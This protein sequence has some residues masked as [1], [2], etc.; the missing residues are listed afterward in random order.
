MTLPKSIIDAIDAYR[1]RVRDGSFLL[2]D[3]AREELETTIAKE[4]Q[5]VEPTTDA[6]VEAWEREAR[7]ADL[8][9]CTDCPGELYELRGEHLA[10]GIDLMRRARAT[11][12]LEPTEKSKTQ[13]K[14]YLSSIDYQISRI[15]RFSRPGQEQYNSSQLDAIAMIRHLFNCAMDGVPIET[16]TGTTDAQN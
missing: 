3:A 7:K 5:P 11:G 6:E 2:E 8:S 15:A 1:D 12:S 13:R 14:Q 4:I 10:K 9:V 16:I